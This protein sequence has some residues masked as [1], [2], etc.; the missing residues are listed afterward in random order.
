MAPRPRGFLSEHRREPRGPPQISL[1]S[2]APHAAGECKDRNL[3][4]GD[5]VDQMLSLLRA[6]FHRVPLRLSGGLAMDACEIAGLC[7]LPD[8]DKGT[9]VESIA[10]MSGF[11]IL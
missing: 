11:M 9:F 5:L 7:N 4:G 3:Q 2:H 8:R 6:E 1:N 10:W